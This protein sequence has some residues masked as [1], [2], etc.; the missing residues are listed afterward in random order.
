LVDERPQTAD[1]RKSQSWCLVPDESEN[2]NI[3]APNPK[4]IM[5][6]ESGGI[7]QAFGYPTSLYGQVGENDPQDL[8]RC[9]IVVAHSDLAPQ[10]GFVQQTPLFPFL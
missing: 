5:K 9:I 4:Q 8:S 2:P 6:S 10:S 7:F 1:S 3:E